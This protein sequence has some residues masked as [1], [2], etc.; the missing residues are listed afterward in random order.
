MTGSG[1]G[2]GA[3]LAKQLAEAGYALAIH[4]SKSREGADEVKRT[5]ESKG[6]V[7]Q[8]FQ[9]DLRAESGC[10][11][12]IEQVIKAFGNLD[13][14]INNSGVYVGGNLTEISEQEWWEG[15]QTTAAAAFFT[16]RAAL[17]YLRKSG[18]GRVVNIGDSSCDRPGARD[19]AIGYHIGKTGVLMVTRS[20]AQSEA[21]YG[22]TVNLVSP[23][24]LENSVGLPPVDTLPAGRYGTFDDIWQAVSFF[25]DEKNGYI[26]G[27]NVIASGGW[28]LR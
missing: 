25:L 20:F 23:G 16:T 8:I 13:A 26:T 7:A 3:H 2:L 12:L 5:T 27:S 4:Y 28:N 9:A 22:I 17:P 10:V 6:G 21:K 15:I 18:S 14:L 19:L 24:Y 1:R 11:Q